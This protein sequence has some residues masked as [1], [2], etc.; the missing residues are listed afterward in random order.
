MASKAE[1]L[2]ST[3]SIGKGMTMTFLRNEAYLTRVHIT[4]APDA[5][6]LYVPPHWHETHD[7]YIR[8]LSGQLE[9]V[10]GGQTKVY[11]PEDG[12]AT[13]PKGVVHS[14]KSLKGIEVL[15]EERT[16]PKDEEKELFFR[17]ILVSGGMPTNVLEVMHVFYHGD[18]VPA[19][20]GHVKWLEKAFVTI[21]GAYIAPALGHKRKYPSL[22][23]SDPVRK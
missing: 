5:D 3:I 6:K 18:T 15:F 19:L 21:L 7:E 4:G 20:P 9:I 17:N 22:N 16:N 1:E 11:C 12:E 14:L 23:M 8:V 13:I 10:V 2:P